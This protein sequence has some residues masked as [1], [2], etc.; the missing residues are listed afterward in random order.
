M[1]VF[2]AAIA[3]AV[4][5]LPLEHGVAKTKLMLDNYTFGLPFPRGP[6]LVAPGREHSNCDYRAEHTRT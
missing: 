4:V 3:V 5:I 2:V 6:Q 1:S